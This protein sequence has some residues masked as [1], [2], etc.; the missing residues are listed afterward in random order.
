MKRSMFAAVMVAMMVMGVKT[1]AAE[2]ETDFAKAST[3]ASK[4]GSYMLLDFSGSDWCGWCIRLDEEVFSKPAFKKY[5]KENLVLVM[6]DFPRRKSQNKKLKDQNAALAAKYNI[7]GYPTVLVLSPNGELVGRTG[8]K[9]GGDKKY[10]EHLKKMID[11]HK[12]KQPA[13]PAAK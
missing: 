11:E 6:V 1:E 4:S 8:Y 2:W 3:N 10:V 12:Q 7:E 9:D 5:A 13:A